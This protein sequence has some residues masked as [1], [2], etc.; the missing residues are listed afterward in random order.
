M[1]PNTYLSHAPTENKKWGKN[2]KKRLL[3]WRYFLG[4]MPWSLFAGRKYM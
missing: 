4:H 3:D 1:E 2:L